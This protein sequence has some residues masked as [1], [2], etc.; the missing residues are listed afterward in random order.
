MQFMPLGKIFQKKKTRP[1]SQTH[2]NSAFSLASNSGCI[3]SYLSLHANY[4]DVKLL[5]VGDQLHTAV[6]N[7]NFIILDIRV[8]RSDFPALLNEQS[9]R[10]FHYVCLVHSSD[11]CVRVCAR[12][13]AA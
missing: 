11:L 7:N 4:H 9:V 12:A 5:R 3:L 10:L 2:G 6:I 13:K 1:V 8:E